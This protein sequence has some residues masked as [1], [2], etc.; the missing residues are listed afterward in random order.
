[1]PGLLRGN[2]DMGGQLWFSAG[3]TAR[4][5][6]WAPE[7]LR[8]DEL[9]NLLW[10]VDR[11]TD[12]FHDPLIHIRECLGRETFVAGILPQIDGESRDVQQPELFA[13]LFLI[14]LFGPATVCPKHG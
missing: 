11:G 8:A 2:Q 3:S 14:K 13:Q 10:I 5:L 1:M 9:A 7:E 6:K 4:A 12:H